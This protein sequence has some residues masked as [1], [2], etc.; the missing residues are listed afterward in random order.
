MSSPVLSLYDVV[1]REPAA[2]TTGEASFSFTLDQPASGSITFGYYVQ[3]GSASGANGDYRGLAG[4]ITVLTGSGGGQVSIPIL[5]DTVIEPNET[6]QLVFL[7]PANATLAGGA[8]ALIGTATILDAGS[9]GA[10]GAGPLATGVAGPL[11]ASASLPTLSVHDVAVIEGDG[12]S[13]AARFLITFDQPLT[14]AATFSYYFQDG[15][16]IAG[17]DY[18]GQPGTI[19]VGAGQQ[20]AYIAATV[21]GD[22]SNEGDETF[23]LIVT[24]PHGAVLAHNAGALV[25]TATIIDNDG[26]APDAA[27][28]VGADAAILTSGLIPDNDV[29]G[30][31]RADIVWRHTSGAVSEWSFGGANGDQLRQSVYNGS[32]DPS[33]HIVDTFDLNGDGRAD[34]LWRNA[35]GQVAV[36]TGNADASL[37]GAFVSEAIGNDWRIAGA[38]DVNGD[39]RG[40]LVWQHNDGAV[41]I[42]SSTGTGFV[43]NAYYHASVGANWKIEGVADLNGDGRSDIVWRNTDGTV[44]TWLSTD[45]GFREGVFS[46]QVAGS[47]HMA[48]LGDF[49]GDG[50]ADILWRNDDG[51]L[52]VWHSNGTGFDQDY[53]TTVGTEWHVAEVGDVN[54]D[55]RA[56]LVWRN[57]NGAVASWTSTGS[58]FQNGVYDNGV[59]QDWSIVGH[60]FPL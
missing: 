40:D 10:T 2:G 20:S 25:A 57:D 39:G 54:G 24:D 17:S 28:G 56:D 1:V 34:I 3:D 18:S 44:S 35:N 50:K 26:H 8:A 60:A 13:A 48:G 5:P 12:G 19:T 23:K 29:N 30:D 53:Y 55:G 43:E 59:G 15:S 9:T 38:G 32:A 33:W 27:G 47:W 21:T 16:A 36:W 4:N 45:G 11:S 6:L 22:T 46:S 7:K 49:N 58:G 14:A 37:S 52:A 31:G 41:S 51:G 42:W